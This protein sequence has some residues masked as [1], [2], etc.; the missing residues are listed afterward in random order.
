M[1]LTVLLQIT[2]LTAL[3]AVGEWI[4]KFWN[5]PVPGGVIGLFLLSS[6]LLSGWLAPSKLDRGSQWLLS[7]MLVFI[8]PSM[9]SILDHP[10]FLGLIGIKVLLVIVL[11]SLLTMGMTC[12]SIEMLVHLQNRSELKA[13][14]K[15]DD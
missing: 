1:N 5:S 10:E 8:V 14:L 11:S 7:E 15:N 9:L 12:L 4:A 6:L 13:H 2:F 3:W